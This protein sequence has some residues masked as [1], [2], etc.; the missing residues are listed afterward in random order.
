MH[1]SCSLG[2]PAPRNLP[3]VPGSTWEP[4][5]L[6]SFTDAADFHTEPYAPTLTVRG[7]TGSNAGTTRQVAV[8]TV[9][10]MHGLVIPEVDD[11]WMQHADRLPAGVEWSARIYVRRPEEV[12]GE[13]ARQMNKVPLP[14]PALHRRARA[15]TA[16][17][18][19]PGT[20]GSPGRTAHASGPDLLADGS[21]AAR[22]GCYQ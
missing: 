11:P 1:R 13:L 17:E 10:Q 15:G 5:D 22:L 6:A 20:G 21:R 4:E 9:G 8:L 3:A 2:L 14:G 19:V 16:A 7:R 12:A 18:P